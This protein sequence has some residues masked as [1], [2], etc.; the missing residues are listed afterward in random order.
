MI[1]TIVLCVDFNDICLESLKIL[2]NK[3]DLNN[4]RIH[5][6]HVFEKLEPNSALAMWSVP[7]P[8]QKTEIE[9][10]TIEALARFATQLNLNPDLVQMHCSFEYSSEE[11]IQRYL[12]SVKADLV[13][14]ATRGKHGI[15]G[16]FFSSL[17]DFLCKYSPCDVLVLRPIQIES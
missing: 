1:K 13:V 2:P 11:A 8:E 16:V 7:L 9:K 6:I 3:I 15:L 4:C 10:S 12:Q 17:A 5:L 14:V